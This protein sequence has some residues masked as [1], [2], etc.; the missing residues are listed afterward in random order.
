MKKGVFIFVILSLLSFGL[1]RAQKPSDPR[2]VLNPE[3]HTSSVFDIMLTPDKKTLISVSL[4][5]TI[6]FWDTQTGKLTKTLRC[7]IGDDMEGQIYAGD[8]SP[9][10][11]Y[12]AIGGYFGPTFSTRDEDKIKSGEI[13]LI[14]LHGSDKITVLKGHTSGIN[15]L[16]FSHDGSFLTSAANDSTI[17][18]WDHKNLR[19][20]NVLS[21]HQSTIQEISISGDDRTIVSSGNDGN[22]RIWWADRY[23]SFS[24]RNYKEITCHKGASFYTAISP[25]GKYIVTAG[26]DNYLKLY[27]SN[28]DFIKLIDDFKHSLYTVSFSPDSKKIVVGGYWGFQSVVYEIPSG[29]VIC[30]F[31]KHF[32]SVASSLFYNDSIVYTAELGNMSIRSFNIYNPD[33]ATEITGKGRWGWAVAFGQHDYKIAYSNTINASEA[34]RSSGNEPIYSHNPEYTPL[35]KSFDFRSFTLTTHPPKEEHYRRSITSFNGIKPEKTSEYTLAHGRDTI[36]KYSYYDRGTLDCYTYTEDG[37]LIVGGV[38]SLI[39]YN[40]ERKYIKEFIGHEAEVEGVSISHDNKLLASAAIDHTIKLWDIDRKGKKAISLEEFHDMQVRYYGS[41]EELQSVMEYNNLT[42]ESYYAYYIKEVDKPLVTFFPT[43]DNEWICWAPDYYYT[44]SKNGRKYIGFH[45]NNERDELAAYYPFEQFDLKLNRPDI[46]LKR[47]DPTQT[48]LIYAYHQAY[49]KRLKRMNFTEDMFSDDWHIP[50]VTIPE[51]QQLP[52]TTKEKSFSLKINANDEKYLLDRVNI[53]VNDV[54]I[55][56]LNGI[57][58]RSDKTTSFNKSIELELSN[59]VN[60]IQ[61]SVINQK[62]AESLKETIHIHYIGIQHK[63]NLYLITVG[64][65][66]YQD[67]KWNL[68]Y[69][70]KDAQ[71]ILSLFVNNQQDAYN[72]IYQ[73]TL[74]NEQVTRENVL[75]LK[76]KLMESHVDDLVIIFVAGHG[77]LDEQMDYYIATHDMDFNNPA[78]KGLAYNALENML[79]GIPARKK[80]MLIDACHSGEVDKE[81]ELTL[82]HNYEEKGKVVF[83]SGVDQSNLK[84]KSDLNQKNAFELMKEMFTDLQRG[85]GATIISS[86]GGGEFSLEGSAWNNGVFTAS[87][88]DALTSGNADIDKDGKVLVS[89]LRYYV[90][91]SVIQ[92]TNGLQNPTFRHENI[93]FDFS[94]W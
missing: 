79:D 74:I 16:R 75:N 62:G 35:E 12:L 48:D 86:S 42:L 60:K 50:T 46:V 65:S 52:A 92:L 8:I 58:L 44:C 68:K 73:H 9:D 59:G 90:T 49:K 27:N 43:H 83:R 53:W 81:G 57:D 29:K 25:D 55:Y 56:G 24:A 14:D 31:T 67:D 77:L 89:E 15:A 78:T 7:H 36:V 20:I 87:L 5:K 54:P 76:K 51:K 4:D 47:I 39:L 30:R 38:S 85:T 2:L 91:E 18:L 66:T 6:R 40:K 71:D 61:V 3:G 17:R 93:D 11:R 63:P 34:L 28:G 69:A 21:G 33:E 82:A 80:L 94:V 13:R 32:D 64:T 26:T 84:V 22:L 10:G 88:I 19:T 41:E 70:A 72:N 37:Q 23:G 1:A 45:V